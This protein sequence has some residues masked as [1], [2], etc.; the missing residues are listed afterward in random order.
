MPY[1]LTIAAWVAAASTVAQA[2]TAATTLSV[3]FGTQARL[4]LSQTTINFPDADPDLMPLVSALPGPVT[5][6]AKARAG[7]NSAVTLTLHAIDDLR[8]GVVV[9]PASLLSWTGAGPG[10]AN[11]TV[12]RDSPQVVASWTGS[13]VRSGSQT[14]R[15]SNRWT[16]PA[17]TYSVTLVYTLAA[18]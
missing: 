12:A 1:G 8:S 13:G 17:G 7:R 2:P 14:F 16:H 6:V 5:I 4:Q 15:F 18:P 11:G 10:F 9:L 3:N